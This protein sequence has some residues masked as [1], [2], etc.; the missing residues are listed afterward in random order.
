MF[1]ICQLTKERG[2]TWFNIGVTQWRFF[3]QH[4]ISLKA[5]TASC[6][7]FFTSSPL[8]SLFSLRRS[9]M[10]LFISL[11][12]FLLAFAPCSFWR[13][14]GRRSK[15]NLCRAD[16]YVI[17]WRWWCSKQWG[18]QWWRWEWWWWR[19]EWWS[20]KWGWRK[21]WRR[22]ALILHLHLQVHLQCFNL[23][24]PAS[25]QSL[26]FGCRFPH[27]LSFRGPT[28]QELRAPKVLLEVCQVA[29]LLVL[30][31]I[32]LHPLSSTSNSL[33]LRHVVTSKIYYQL[34]IT[35]E[36]AI[37]VTIKM[38]FPFT[39]FANEQWIFEHFA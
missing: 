18:W 19:W 28:S 21:T 3:R 33:Q 10:I 37:N 32:F 15:T 24:L 13:D 5:S 22:P 4:E 27:L 1:I 11:L 35:I 39:A 38:A 12:C 9:S 2:K 29:F 31:S 26:S 30:C 17:R 36:M 34:K 25:L 6:S 14:P 7:V 23:L 8:N 20:Y 16:D